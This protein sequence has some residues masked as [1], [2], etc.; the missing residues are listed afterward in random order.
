MATTEREN[1]PTTIDWLKAKIDEFLATRPEMSE[2]TFGWRSIKEG[3]LVDRLHAG[4]DITTEKLDRIIAF[5]IENGFNPHPQ[6]TGE[7]K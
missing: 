7:P 2:R 3:G 6:T 5:M 1:Y 4:G